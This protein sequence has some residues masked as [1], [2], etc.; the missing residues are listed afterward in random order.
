[1]G[2]A[3]SGPWRRGW[4]RRFRGVV[5]RHERGAGGWFVRWGLGRIAGWFGRGERGWQMRWSSRWVMRGLL[6]WRRGG[7]DCGD[8]SRCMGWSPRRRQR[9]WGRGGDLG[10]LTGWDWRREFRGV[11]GRASCGHGRGRVGWAFRWRFRG[12]LRWGRSRHLRRRGGRSWG[13]HLGR[14]RGGGLSGLPGRGR[15]RGFRGWEFGRIECGERSGH[16]G[17]EVR[18][19]VRGNVRWF[20]GWCVR[21]LLRW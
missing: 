4:G 2:W 15:Q 16:E 11:R 3:R 19:Q 21:G 20:R 18:R 9:C 17:G 12:L 13:W 5:R 8:L 14:F 1:V 10:R 7:G 6:G